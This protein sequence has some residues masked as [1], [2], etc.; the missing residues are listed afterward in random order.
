MDDLVF[1]GDESPK[2]RVRWLE[3]QPSGQVGDDADNDVISV[4]C[5]EEQYFGMYNTF[6]PSQQGGIRFKTYS[7]DVLWDG[8]C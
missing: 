2:E 8:I 3:T 4:L 1:S 5:Q 7:G 6:S